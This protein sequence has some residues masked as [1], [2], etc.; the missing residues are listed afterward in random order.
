M[1]SSGS[2]SELARRLARNAEAACRHYLPRGRRQGGYWLVGD[3]QGSPGRSLYVRL[4]GPTGGKGAA[5]KWTDASSGEYGDLLDLIGLNLGLP[6]LGEVL[7]E[8]RRFLRE[9][10]H[11]WRSESESRPSDQSLKTR[12]SQN[13]VE[14][15]RRLFARSRPIAGT[16]GET[17]LGVRDIAAGHDDLALRFHPRC[18][19]RD[20]EADRLLELPAVIAAVTDE[21]GAL[22]GVHRTWL[23]V[24]GG[25]KASVASPRRAMGHLLG[26][27]VR[28]GAVGETSP[29]LFAGEGLETMLSL[30]MATPL[31]PVVAALSAA[32]LAGILFPALLRRL[33]V[34][35]DADAAGRRALERLRDRGREV[36]IEVFALHPALG[37]FNDDLRCR[38]LAALQENLRA[39]L[40]DGDAQRFLPVAGRPE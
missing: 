37:D 14:A 21:A 11:Q 39:Q 12:S 36:G 24:D 4:N 35:V 31:A 16:I 19:Y 17:Y 25:A 6:T 22:T 7:D 33:Y 9:Q 27:G 10:Q 13:S 29:I 15:A 26:Y 18:F 3:C 20:V 28:F 5:G 23:S 38:G 32:H 30:R 1:S 2:V 8:A 34:A 40:V